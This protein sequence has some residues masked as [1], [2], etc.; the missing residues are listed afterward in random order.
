VIPWRENP[1][2][3]GISL[4][5]TWI[6]GWHYDP[7]VQRLVFDVEFSLWPGHPKYEEPW[8]NEWTCYKRGRLI[9]EGVRS[10]TGLED[11]G[12]VRPAL[13]ADDKVDYGNFDALNVDGH[14]YEVVGNFG[15]VR[16]S[17]DSVLVEVDHRGR[18]N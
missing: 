17:A 11:Q 12:S 8:P 4:E 2:F 14:A 7:Q 10:L 13:D 15:D 18:A 1:C 5:D 3:N 16:L 9:F 6:E